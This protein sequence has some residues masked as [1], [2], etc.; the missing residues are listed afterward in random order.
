MRPQYALDLWVRVRPFFQDR[1]LSLLPNKQKE[2]FFHV[3]IKP[4]HLIAMETSNKM[5]SGSR[6]DKLQA[7][8][9]HLTSKVASGGSL[10]PDTAYADF[11]K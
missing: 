7:R 11:I 3:T 10:L 6:Y 4:S 2:E 5:A 8:Y 9:N 1:F